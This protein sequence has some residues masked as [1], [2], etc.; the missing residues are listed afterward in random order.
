[1]ERTATVPVAMG[2]Q[3]FV[4]STQQPATHS[5]VVFSPQPAADPG[6]NAASLTGIRKRTMMTPFAGSSPTLKEASNI[7]N[8]GTVEKAAAPD[9]YVLCVFVS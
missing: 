1:M 4:R 6:P 7:E 2:A 3:G 9:R 8:L 5:Q